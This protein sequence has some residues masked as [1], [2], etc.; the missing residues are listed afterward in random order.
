MIKHKFSISDQL[1][2]LFFINT[3]KEAQAWGHMKFDFFLHFLDLIYVFRRSKRCWKR[4][5]NWFKYLTRKIKIII[6]IG[7]LIVS[8]RSK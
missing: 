3:Q 2:G 4:S 6:R 8:W 1:Y 5:N 7:L